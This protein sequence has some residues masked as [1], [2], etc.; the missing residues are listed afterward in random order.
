[1]L[2]KRIIPSLL[3]K[4]G[5]MV[6]GIQFDNYKN[7]GEPQSTVEIYTSQDSDELMFINISDEEKYKSNFKDIIH[8]VSKK[9]EMPLTVGGGINNFKLIDEMF[10]AGAD[11]ILINSQILKDLNFLREFIK[12][13]GTQALIVGIDYKVE[14]GLHVCI[15]IVQK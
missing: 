6:K 15:Q 13:H 7:V 12:I 11:K 4:N 14:D 10:N 9:C 8:Q 1:M 3:Y 5:E 2:K